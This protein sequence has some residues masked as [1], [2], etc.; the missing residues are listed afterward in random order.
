VLVM[1]CFSTLIKLA[2]HRG[3]LTPCDWV[4]LNREC[5]YICECCGRISFPGQTRP[6]DDL[7]DLGF[8][9]RALRLTSARASL[10]QF[11]FFRSVWSGS[12]HSWLLDDRVLVHLS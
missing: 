7:R 1:E 2:D 12:K 10:S 11:A 9:L 3:L 5:R 8:V 6:N 4:R